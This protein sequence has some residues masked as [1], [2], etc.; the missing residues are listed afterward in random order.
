MPNPISDPV[1][2]IRRKKLKFRAW[3]RGFREADLI[4][5]P[6][7]DQNLAGFSED[8]LDA[9]ETL[10][11]QLDHDLYGWIVGQAEAPEAFRGE[12]LERL[13]EFRFTLHGVRGDDLGA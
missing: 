8:Q 5:G 13:R 9:F 4:L 11:D 3:H 12:M 7:A 2:E 1:G 10:I 6:F